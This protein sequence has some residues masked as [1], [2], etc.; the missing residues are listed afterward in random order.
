LLTLCGVN[1]IIVC[2]TNWIPHI[3]S[4]D[5][6]LYKQLAD[7]IEQDIFSGRLQ[8]GDKLP[9]HRDLADLLKMNVTTVTKGY[10]EAERRGL[11][12]GTVGR[13]TYVASDAGSSTSMVSHEPHAPGMIELGLV[14]PMYHL[15]PDLAA[16]LKQLCRKRD[17]STLMHYSD[18]GG[19]PEH[20]VVG[21][22]W[23]NRFGLEVSS[24]SV[25]ICS[26]AQHALTCTLSGL[27]RPGDRI[28][29]DSLTYPGMKTLASMLGLRLVPV[30]M[31]KSGMVAESLDRICR[32][33][34]I[35]GLYL[36]PGVHN[37]TTTTIPEFRRESLAKVVIRHDLIVIE[38]DAYDLTRP[39]VI[40]P[41]SALIPGNGIYIAGISKALAAGLRVAFIVIPQKYRRPI[42]EAILNTTW[43][44]PPLNVELVS[45]WIRDGKAD[46]VI[47]LKRKE[48]AKRFAMAGKI[49]RDYSFTGQA[50]GFFIWLSLPAPWRG[51]IFEQRMRE[52]GVNVFGAEKFTVGDAPAPAAARISLTGTKSIDELA[53]GL[54]LI[55]RVL[56]GELQAD[57]PVTM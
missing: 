22:E 20:R 35:K 53:A 54:Q 29:T 23:A 21:A 39:G 47:D 13:G 16:G 2:M 31:D 15:D 48:A 14:N 38:D 3:Q 25:M 18:P 37:P 36:M 9:T 50:T 57:F 44:T 4:S 51:L 26:G 5:T 6:P 30:E 42:R 28:A 49:L 27:F 17:I 45:M 8:P 7:T 34:Q 24:N 55:K 52:L 43:M 41:L 11:I 56:D 10:K 33:E 1:V 40:P 32:R 12:A 19:L 46:K